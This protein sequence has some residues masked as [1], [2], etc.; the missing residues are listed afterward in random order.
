MNIMDSLLEVRGGDAMNTTD[1]GSGGGAGG[2]IKIKAQRIEGNGKIDISG[3]KGSKGGGG[4]GSG[5][6]L[7]V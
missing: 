2:S 7:K 6:Y 5:G 1:L 3:G 4:G